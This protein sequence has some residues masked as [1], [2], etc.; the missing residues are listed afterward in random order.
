V[1]TLADAVDDAIAW[2]AAPSPVDRPGS[3]PDRSKAP[4]SPDGSCTEDA[5]PQPLPHSA[6][7]PREREVAALVARGYSNRQI[8]AALVISP[9]TAERHVERILDRLNLS[10]RAGIAAWAARHGLSD[11]PAASTVPALKP[12]G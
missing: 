5:T 2:L 8:A 12:A 3:R 4:A 11:A 9:H 6:L 7:T 10:S 1:L